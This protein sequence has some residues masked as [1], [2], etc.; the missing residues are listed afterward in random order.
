MAATGWG[1]AAPIGPD[2]MPIGHPVKAWYDTG[3]F[4]CEGDMGYDGAQPDVWF[5]DA[6]AAQ[7]A[8]FRHGLGD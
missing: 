1:S 5:I 8:G 4:V 6:E 2:I 7:R 3:S